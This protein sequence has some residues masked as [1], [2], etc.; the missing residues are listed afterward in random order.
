ME[1][2]ILKK[3]LNNIVQLT[4]P[5][6][7]EQ[8]NKLGG[9]QTVCEL[10]QV[11]PENGLS[12]DDEI[13]LKNRQIQFD[14]NKIEKIKSKSF[15]YLL[16]LAFH[17]NLLIVLTICALISI[18]LSSLNN[19]CECYRQMHEISFMSDWIDG[20]AILIA[21]L[22][23]LIVTAFNNWTKERQ[24]QLLQVK[25]ESEHKI[26]VLRDSIIKEIHINDICVG[27]VCVLTTGNII[28][29]DGILINGNDLKIDESAMTGE[30]ELVEKNLT[31]DSILFSSMYFLNLIK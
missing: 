9:L 26:N 12:S 15:F 11:D 29:A 23:V 14:S 19:K 10:L 13:D 30:S 1:F 7:N 3:D 21:V 5:Q 31:N 25:L 2:S 20:I 18:L 27:D 24:F 17:D 6:R 22:I 28:P 4:N 8:L 16:W